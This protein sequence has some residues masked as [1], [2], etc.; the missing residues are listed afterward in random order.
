MFITKICRYNSILKLFSIIYQYFYSVLFSIFQASYRYY[1]YYRL[2]RNIGLYFRWIYQAIFYFFYIS[3]FSVRQGVVSIATND[4]LKV[5]YLVS[6]P[7]GIKHLNQIPIS[8]SWLISQREA[9]HCHGAIWLDDDFSRKRSFSLQF[10][11]QTKYSTL[12]SF[13]R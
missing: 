10:F 12:Y 7:G 3:K 13:R 11:T 8:F 9:E 5:L 4:N 6:A 1:R 2:D